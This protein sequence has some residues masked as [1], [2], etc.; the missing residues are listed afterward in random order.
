MRRNVGLQL[1]VT[2]ARIRSLIYHSA[3]DWLRATEELVD[4]GR[5]GHVP[6]A[7][8]ARQWR[9]ASAAIE[10]TDMMDDDDDFDFMSLVNE[11]QGVGEDN[12]ARDR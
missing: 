4:M 3:Q 12:D 7:R 5:V 2:V 9:L 8:S 10:E 1:I 11:A 6:S